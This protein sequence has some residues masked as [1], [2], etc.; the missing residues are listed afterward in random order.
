M[1]LDFSDG[2]YIWV[3]MDIV[4]RQIED[5]YGKPVIA[6]NNG[7]LLLKIAGK[8]YLYSINE[9]FQ[10]KFAGA[11]CTIIGDVIGIAEDKVVEFIENT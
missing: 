7:E 11:G 5:F 2:C 1:K 8:D 3:N 4:D 10:D 9:E 6:N